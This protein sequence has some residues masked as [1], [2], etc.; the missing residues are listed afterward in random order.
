ML[1]ELHIQNFR[2]FESLTIEGLKRVNLF[3][4]KNNSGKTALLEALRIMAADKDVSVIHH[5]L[6]QRGQPV[7]NPLDAY[8]PLFNT[9]ALE[10]IPFNEKTRIKIGQLAIERIVRAKNHT[11]YFVYKGQEKGDSI[12]LLGIGNPPILPRDVAVFIPF[13]ATD[14]FPLERL[15]DAIVLTPKEDK[16]KEI[17]QATILPNLVRLDV[18]PERTLVRLKG[19]EKPLPLK[20]LGD[21]AQRMLLIAIALVSAK[22]NMLL[23]DEMDAGLHYSVLERLWE[24][25]F[26][27]A[28]ELN[29]QVF[30]TTHSSDAIK[31]F[32]YTLEKLDKGEQGAYFRLQNDRKTA[33]PE[34]IAYDL[35]RMENALES[36]LEIR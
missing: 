28:E 1:T 32:V 29:V 35:E 13:G 30:A 7:V 3:A 20:S 2:L 9:S 22:D 25:I 26:R 19:E 6:S 10:H 12:N 18:K 21:G 31:S 23:L 17:M 15:W 14:Y 5:I 16:V 24:I 11:Q 36:N 27:Y 4:G 33:Q 34:V 8:D